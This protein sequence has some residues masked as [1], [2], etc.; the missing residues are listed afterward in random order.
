MAPRSPHLLKGRRG[1]KKPSEH[2]YIDDL[3]NLT[4]D[5]GFKDEQGDSL[6]MQYWKK[7]SDEGSRPMITVVPWPSWS[8]II[9]TTPLKDMGE[10]MHIR[11]GGTRSTLRL[12]NENTEVT[13]GVSSEARESY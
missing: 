11:I 8:S 6:A 5:G 10:H 9:S 12:E 3:I 4:N 1:S 7:T 13:S 2:A